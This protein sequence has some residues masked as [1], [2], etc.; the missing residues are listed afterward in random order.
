ML[1]DVLVSND[2]SKFPDDVSEC[3]A[4]LIRSQVCRLVPR[5]NA[6]ILFLCYK[7]SRPLTTLFRGSFLRIH[8]STYLEGKFGLMWNIL[9]VAFGM[10]LAV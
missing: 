5:N 7:D 10:P 6:N 8:P 3:F 4:K 9:L 1:H 2:S